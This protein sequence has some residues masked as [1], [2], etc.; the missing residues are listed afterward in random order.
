MGTGGENRKD[1]RMRREA[2]L[3]IL[4]GSAA[5]WLILHSLLNSGM[6][7]PIR[8]GNT[9][10]R[11]WQQPGSESWRGRAWAMRSSHRTAQA[12]PR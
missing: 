1:T 4:T 11:S 6:D 2:L 9:V 5:M 12:A 8:R 7:V 10:E 3:V